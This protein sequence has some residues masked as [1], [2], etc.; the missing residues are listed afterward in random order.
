MTNQTG[1]HWPDRPARVY[2]QRNQWQYRAKADEVAILGNTWYKL[3]KT[4]IEARYAY[5]KMRE[6]LDDAGGMDRLFSRF[7]Q[8]VLQPNLPEYSERTIADKLI[9]IDKLRKVFGRMAPQ[10][11]R[12]THC[13]RYLD[14]RGKA[15]KSQA[16]QEFNTLSVVF[17]YAVRWGVVD[18]NP[19]LGISRH[20]IKDR[21]RL[22][23]HQEIAAFCAVS[24]PFIQRYTRFKYK[25]GLRQRDILTLTVRQIDDA[26]IHVT[27]SKTGKK[28]LIGWDD[29]LRE[30]VREIISANKIQ[31]ETLFCTAR[32]L[33]YSK[34]SFDSRW[35]YC[36]TKAMKLGV[37]KER[38]WEHDIRASHATEAEDAHGLDATDQ[39]LHDNPKQ[40]QTYL[41]N[42]KAT[43]ITPLPYEK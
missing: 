31:G 37:I 32:G 2:W 1:Q 43:K 22:P 10:H 24:T 18:K 35:Q 16:N 34:T 26:G 33:P 14:E 28:G 36:M 39:L 3:G 9:H 20:K 25:T 17:K 15:S 40:K 19:C 5:A 41:R 11:V 13:A 42:K 21:T 6:M 27:T 30:L 8:Y 29:E 4:A 38:F 7:V 23:T 12:P